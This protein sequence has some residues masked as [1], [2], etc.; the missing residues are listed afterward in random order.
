MLHLGR[1]KYEG[2]MLNWL[3]RHATWKLTGNLDFIS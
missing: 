2:T 1:L 3:E